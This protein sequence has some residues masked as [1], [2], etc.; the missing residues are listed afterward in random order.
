VGEVYLENFSPPALANSTDVYMEQYARTRAMLDREG[1]RQ[2]TTLL[3]ATYDA[4]A[5][6]IT[7][8]L[9]TSGGQDA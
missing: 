5:A 6:F 8:S 4:C 1:W 3:K 2:A 9:A 7:Q